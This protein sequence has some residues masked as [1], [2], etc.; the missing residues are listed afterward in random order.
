VTARRE[1]KRSVRTPATGCIRAN[2]QRYS[3]VRSPS[4]AAFRTN[5]ACKS[6]MT[7]AGASRVKKANSPLTKSSPRH[8]HRYVSTRRISA[9]VRSRR[10]AGVTDRSG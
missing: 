9:G 2:G 4:S 6:G 5:A 7:T 8:T 10:S 1:P 3:E